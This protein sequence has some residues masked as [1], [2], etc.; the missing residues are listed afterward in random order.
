MSGLE[1]LKKTLKKRFGEDV[2]GQDTSIE[3]L[4]SGILSLDIALGGGWPK[5]R[6]VSINGWESSGKTT[7]CLQGLVAPVQ[8]TGK[9]VA[10]IDSEYAIDPD[11]SKNIGVS[12]DPDKLIL[13]QPNTAEEAI[14]IARECV[15]D[16]NIGAIVF[17]S[18]ASMVPNAVLQGEA[19]DQKMGVMAR[20]LSQWVP[21][22]LSYAKKT[23]CIIVFINQFREKI[24]VMYG[25]PTT[26]P[27]GKA[28]KFYA[29]QILDVARCGQEKEGDTILANKTRV[30]VSKNKVAAPYKKAEFL[31]EFGTG[32][33]VFQD[34]IDTAIDVGV[35]E[36]KGAW[37]Y[38]NG[39]TI[40][41][42]AAAA[43]KWASENPKKFEEIRCEILNRIKDESE[44]SKGK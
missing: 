41:Q 8:K 22:L 21:T 31:I 43:K 9:A 36:S 29:S 20:L 30:K 26:V 6:V 15:K 10:Y 16:P 32:V 17:D 14:E 42:G 1:E 40:G 34:T 19:G 39:K 5:G 44:K 25:D 35:I 38:Y 4:S 33:D 18:V 3:L 24:G 37:V 7:I 12:F 2:F 13:F 23:G 28:I 27:G 11:Y